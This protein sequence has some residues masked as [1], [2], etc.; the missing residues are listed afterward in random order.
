MASVFRKLICKELGNNS[1]D[2][3]FTCYQNLIKDKKYNHH[4]LNNEE[5]YE[6]ILNKVEEEDLAVLN[7]RLTHLS[8][9]MF[10]VLR[11]SRTYKFTVLV[12]IAS[13]LFLLIYGVPFSVGFVSISLI[14]GCFL[15][16]TYE[17]I[18]NKF[19]FIDAHIVII[20]KSVL[21]RLIL[22]KT[23]KSLKK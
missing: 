14:T 6:D 19:C 18:V 2:K 17:Y 8:D 16:K 3:Y 21:D 23:I 5:I 4:E 9:S 15:Y 12:F 22:A 13:I 10:L 7:K 20:Y 1:Y 11:I